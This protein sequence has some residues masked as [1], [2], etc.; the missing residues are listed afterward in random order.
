MNQSR[1]AQT[2]QNAEFESKTPKGS[3]EFSVPVTSVHKVEADGVRVFYRAA[4]HQ[5]S[6][7]VLRR[8]GNR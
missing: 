1:S 3:S 6:K 5:V 8:R 7:S 2:T 4:G